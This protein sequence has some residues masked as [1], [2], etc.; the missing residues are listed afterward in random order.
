[1]DTL[2]LMVLFHILFHIMLL[3]PRCL[4]FVVVVVVAASAADVVVVFV[5]VG[6]QPLCIIINIINDSLSLWE[7]CRKFS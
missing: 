4:A 6:G 2:C 3:I 7:F 1:M 5:I